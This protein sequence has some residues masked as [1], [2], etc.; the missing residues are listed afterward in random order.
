VS[1]RPEFVRACFVDKSH[2]QGAAPVPRGRAEPICF[3][4]EAGCSSSAIAQEPRYIPLRSLVEFVWRFGC[5][6]GK[7]ARDRSGVAGIKR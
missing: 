4:V 1:I 7:R 3:D 6:L 5:N 2:S